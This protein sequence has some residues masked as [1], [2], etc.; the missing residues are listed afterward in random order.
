MLLNEFLKERRK[1]EELKSAM[2]QQQKDFEAAISRQR[3]ETEV[4]ATRLNDQ[5]ARIQKV[6]A[7]IEMHESDTQMLVRDP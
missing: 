1:V 2:A 7:R 4:L 3:K 6:S 5:E